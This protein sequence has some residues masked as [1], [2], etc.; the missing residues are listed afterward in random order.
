MG[1]ERITKDVYRFMVQ[2]GNADANCILYGKMR[3]AKLIKCGPTPEECRQW[4]N[5]ISQ[6][7]GHVEGFAQCLKEY[8]EGEHCLRPKGH[9]GE[10]ASRRRLAGIPGRS[11][12]RRVMERL[13][14]Y[15]NHYSSGAEGHPPKDPTYSA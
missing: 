3:N 9:G 11:N 5:S 15:E 13:L 4:R 10:H 12:S 1:D 6:E 14:R 2:G 8:S 7:D